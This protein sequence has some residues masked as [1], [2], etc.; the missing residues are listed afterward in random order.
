MT[1]FGDEARFRD[2]G[3]VHGKRQAERRAAGTVNPVAGTTSVLEAGGG[4]ADAVV[5]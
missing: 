4:H 2:R 1:P 5:P 3:S